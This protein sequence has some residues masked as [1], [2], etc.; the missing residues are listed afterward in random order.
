VEG[1]LYNQTSAGERLTLEPDFH[2]GE[3][4]GSMWKSGS[5]VSLPSGER[6]TLKPNFQGELS[7]LGQVWLYKPT[8]TAI[9]IPTT[10]KGSSDLYDAALN[11]VLH[12]QPFGNAGRGQKLLLDTYKRSDWI[13][14][15]FFFQ[16]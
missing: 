7:L 6:L 1:S 3:G 5:R 14:R 4:S 16:Y 8:P 11:T 13:V 10:F 2:R 15:N 12:G 9:F